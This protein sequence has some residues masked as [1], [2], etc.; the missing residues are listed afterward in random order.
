MEEKGLT[1]RQVRRLTGSPGYVVDYL[2]DS[3]RLP[4]VKESQGPGY[5]RLYDPSAVEIVKKHLEKRRS[6]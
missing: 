5:P 4:V 6:D 2:H 3:G 1:K